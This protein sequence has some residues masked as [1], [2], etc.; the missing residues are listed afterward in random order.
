[1]VARPRPHDELESPILP[2]WP[3]ILLVACVLLFFGASIGGFWAL[4]EYAVPDRELPQAHEAPQPRLQAYP[5]ADLQKVVA[6]Q[7]ARLQGYRWIDQGQGIAAIPIDR[8]MAIIAARGSDAYAPIPGAPSPPA[9]NIPQRLQDLRS[10]GQ[11]A[12]E[13]ARPP[14]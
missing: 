12:P 11:T 8:A 7:K 13:P 1:M 9:P 2:G 4:F 5:P 6:A 10:Q 14:Q 3:F